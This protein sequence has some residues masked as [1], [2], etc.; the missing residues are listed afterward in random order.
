MENLGDG[1]VVYTAPRGFHGDDSF[2]FRVRDEGRLE[3]TATAHVDVLLGAMR[4]AF[5]VAVAELAVTG[6]EQE[7]GLDI[8][9][10]VYDQIVQ[11]L[12]E[13]TDVDVE[14]AEPGV[15]RRSVR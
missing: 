10:A 5:N 14:V 7:V 2:V 4:G 12:G 15:V 3:T 11:D 1:R 13:Q 6:A 9:E 8:S